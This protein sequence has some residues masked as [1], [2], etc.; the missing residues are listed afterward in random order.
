MVNRYGTSPLPANAPSACGQSL[1]TAAALV[2][3]L[4]SERWNRKE[5]S[6]EAFRAACSRNL[7]GAVRRLDAL[8]HG[9]SILDGKAPSK[10]THEPDAAASHLINTLSLPE[11][12]ALLHFQAGDGGFLEGFHALR[13]QWELSA[14]ESGADFMKLL[15]KG[16]LTSAY[17]AGYHDADVSRAFDVIAVTKPLDAVDKPLEALR[18]LQRRLAEG[19]ALY[20]L[21]P[22]CARSGFSLCGAAHGMKL[23]VAHLVTLCKAAGLS[24]EH[25]GTQGE[26]IHLCARKPVSSP[27]R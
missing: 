8:L 2:P 11:T 9:L 21:Q 20:L 16:F 1:P 14:I 5:S 12:G 6:L 17:N 4:L 22:P 10:E 26:A 24:I 3:G 18:W 7:S 27:E 19:G 13:P 15:D 25:L 23:R